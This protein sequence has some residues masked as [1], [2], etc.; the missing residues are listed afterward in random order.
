VTA[1]DP[2]VLTDPAFRIGLP[3]DAPRWQ[4]RMARFSDGPDH[5][6]RR[7]EVVA[8]VA[9]LPTAA[10]LAAAARDRTEAWLALSDRNLAPGGRMATT[11]HQVSLRSSR[12][13]GML[14]ARRV[15]VATLAEA[16][17]VP[18]DR[19]DEVVHHTATVVAS[20]APRSG[21]A[22]VRPAAADA[23]VR[24]LDA[25]LPGG[26]AAL[27]ILF[28][29]HDATAALIGTALVTGLPVD[30]VFRDAPPVTSTRRVGPDGQPVVVDLA[31]H[32]FGAGPHAC[33]GRDQAV[34][35]ATGVLAGISAAG[36]APVPGPVTYEDRPN[37]RL[38]AR[39]S[40]SPRPGWRSR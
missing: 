36:W 24:V 38:P 33:P 20:V 21:P 7:A 40:L 34:A 1:S 19:V 10:D 35:L 30:D 27:S 15:P 37:L 16:L 39:L 22:P 13:D 25:L 5:A 23:A 14:L 3:A 6:G 11:R 28:Q 9:A 31:G 18:G 26:T 32:P 2:D 8:L 29:A 12:V 17:G 4:A